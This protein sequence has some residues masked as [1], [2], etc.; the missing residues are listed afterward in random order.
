MEV[1]N[2]NY[3]GVKVDAE[4]VEAVVSIANAAKANADALQQLA[5]SLDLSNVQVGPMI[6]MG[7]PNED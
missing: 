2:C 4:V 5:R 1:T 6:N 7:M 3:T